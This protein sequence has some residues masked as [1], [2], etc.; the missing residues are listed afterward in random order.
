MNTHRPFAL[1][2]LATLSLTTTAAQAE[3]HGKGLK[4]P[5]LMQPVTPLFGTESVSKPLPAS[6]DLTKWAI[7]PGSQGPVNS[8]A[9]WAI[10][11]TLTG[12]YA[13]AN[14]QAHKLFAPMYLYSQ[15]DDGVDAGSTMEAPLDVALEQGI[16]T[17][18]H[19]SW[20]DYDFK[21]KPTG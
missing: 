13:N 10:G 5:S 14:K 3:V 21:H 4:P 19:Y 17:E 20:G 12:W 9:S 15:V 16:D 6:V 18:Q 8:C 11:Y 1:C 7:T 2:L